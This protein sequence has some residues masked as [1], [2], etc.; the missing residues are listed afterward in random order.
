MNK[1]EF[2]QELE[3]RLRYIPKEDR[4]DALQYYE[5]Y[6]EDMGIG[7]DED[8]LSKLGTPKDVSRD[9]IDE[10]A[11]K[12]AEQA[13]ETKTVKSKATVAWLTVLGLLS[14]PISLPLAIA[15]IA[16]VLALLITL[17]AVL[18]A[19]CV[20][21]VAGIISGVAAFFWGLLVAGFGQKLFTMGVGLLM[22]GIGILFFLT[23]A[24][25]TKGIINIFRRRRM[26]KMAEKEVSY[27]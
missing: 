1:R 6:I 13:E 19:L 7:E 14:L 18:F 5:E 21:S 22:F 10:C 20:V 23:V 24:S 27:E 4:I 16:I 8:V 15:V 25:L 2:L 17:F 9:I 3:K 11:I 12:H 26:A